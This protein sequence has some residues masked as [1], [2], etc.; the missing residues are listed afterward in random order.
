MEIGKS[1]ATFNGERKKRSYKWK[2]E[3][4]KLQ[5]VRG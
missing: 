4:V 2:E 1:E 5:I 3:K